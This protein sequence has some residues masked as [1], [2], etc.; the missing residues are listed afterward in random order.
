MRLQSGGNKS[1]LKLP[2]GQQTASNQRGDKV[3]PTTSPRNEMSHMAS[4][5]LVPPSS[6]P[7]S[8][9]QATRSRKPKSRLE[10]RM[11][12]ERQAR[13]RAPEPRVPVV[14]RPTAART[15]HMAEIA[16]TLSTRHSCSDDHGR[17]L[18]PTYPVSTVNA[19]VPSV[20]AEALLQGAGATSRGGSREDDAAMQAT[21]WEREG[22]GGSSRNRP[23]R[24]TSK[25]GMAP[26]HG[27][28]SSPEG[29]G[30]ESREERAK[31]VKTLK[32][33]RG[34]GE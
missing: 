24:G 4:P 19:P 16:K 21:G 34:V 15:Q 29:L 3:A 22:N 26:S 20:L 6:C 27:G 25:G 5:S 17:V 11:E 7:F 8:V 32:V 13:A 12:E 23:S 1:N 9:V 28:C 30:G 18:C 14:S 2:F 10:S 31:A 33:R